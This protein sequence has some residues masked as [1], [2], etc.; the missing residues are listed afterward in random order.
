MNVSTQL[1]TSYQLGFVPGRYIAENG[2]MTQLIMEDARRRSE[3]SRKAKLPE[4]HD[5]GI[6]LDQEK[7]YDRVNL[8]YL[9]KVLEK[10]GFPD[11]IVSCIYNLLA[12]NKIKV[13]VNGHYTDSVRKQRGL[14][15]GDPIS[16]ILYNLAF[17][18]FLRGVLS[19]SRM[20]GYTMTLREDLQVPDD[21]NAPLTTKLLCYADDVLIFVHNSADLRLLQSHKT[22]FCQA[23]N[24]RF[25]YHKT[26]AFSL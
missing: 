12:Y 20:H 17:E 16:P 21:H 13:N 1:I 14:K 23:S 25:N 6:L 8:D 15:Q 22:R 11:L 18:P 10:F 7:A 26:E 5:I 3:I 24:T 2:M 9:R 19:D 4:D